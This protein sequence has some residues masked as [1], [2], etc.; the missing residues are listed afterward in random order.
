[1]SKDSI[2][3]ALDKRLIGRVIYIIATVIMIVGILPPFSDA[4]VD[5]EIASTLLRFVIRYEIKA[6]ENYIHTSG[7]P[8]VKAP[9]NANIIIWSPIRSYD[10]DY[11]QLNVAAPIQVWWYADGQLIEVQDKNEAILEYRQQFMENPKS[12]IWSWGYYAFGMLSVSRFR[13]L[14]DVYV[15]ASCGPLCGH[16]YR[17]K[18]LRGFFGKWWIIQAEHLWQA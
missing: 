11:P 8:W 7:Q 14:A 16:G 18:L 6:T 15:E 13:W 10:P 9:P 2:V 4:Q 12:N 5:K 3:R 1:M 17:Y